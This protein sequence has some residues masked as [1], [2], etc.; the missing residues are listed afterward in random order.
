MRERA[1]ELGGRLV[2]EAL[3]AGGTCVR[4][5]LPLPEEEG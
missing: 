2:V 5:E 3:P 4:A 1:T